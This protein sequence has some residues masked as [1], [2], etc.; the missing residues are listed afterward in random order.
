MVMSPT[1]PPGANSR[2]VSRESSGS[3][4]LTAVAQAERYAFEDSEHSMFVHSAPNACVVLNMYYLGSMKNV[5]EEPCHDSPPN[6]AWWRSLPSRWLA[7]YS[8]TFIIGATYLAYVAADDDTVLRVA[9]VIAATYCFVV[10]ILLWFKSRFVLKAYTVAGLA[11]IGWGI[12]REMSS[13]MTT[14]RI[15]MLIGRLLIVLSYSS[16]AEILDEQKP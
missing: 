3:F 6:H 4:G 5:M 9:T 14:N 8:L 2:H 12:F 11:V 1:K 7:F 10:G 13:G 15:G 16:L